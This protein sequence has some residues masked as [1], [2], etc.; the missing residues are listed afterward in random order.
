M[1]TE[2]TKMMIGDMVVTATRKPDGSVTLRVDPGKEQVH[3][4]MYPSK[5]GGYIPCRV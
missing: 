4:V 2:A 1:P 5:P 3:L